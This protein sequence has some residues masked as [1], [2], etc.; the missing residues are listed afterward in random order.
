MCTGQTILDAYQG[1]GQDNAYPAENSW[2]TL[3]NTVFTK[4]KNLKTKD[5]EMYIERT[6]IAL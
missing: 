1:A 4:E 3:Q 5:T 6:I 2:Q